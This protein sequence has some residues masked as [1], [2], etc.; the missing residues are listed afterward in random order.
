MN[1]VRSLAVALMLLLPLPAAATPV[2]WLYSYGTT[3]AQLWQGST[4]VGLALA[5]MSGT[6]STFDAAI[7]ALL[8]FEFVIDD[9]SVVLGPLGSMDVSL[10]VTPSPGFNAPATPISAT[11][12]TWAGG[13]VDIV[14]SIAFTGGVLNGQTIAV[15]HTATAVNGYFD[16]VPTATE[17]FG[18]TEAIEIF[19]FAIDGVPYQLRAQVVFKGVPIPE[20]TTALLLGFGLVAIAGRRRA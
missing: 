2:T 16:T 8:D 13:P 19:N 14:G 7:P 9:D 18:L 4:P 11:R 1:R 20:P 3:R 6:F 15:N 12:Y 10:T 17:T 5:D